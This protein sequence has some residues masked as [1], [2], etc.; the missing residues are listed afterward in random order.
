MDPKVTESLVIVIAVIL[1]LRLGWL[2]H[3]RSTAR[4]PIHG[5]ALSHACNFLSGLCFV[6]ILP[7]V[8]LSVLVL[9]PEALQLAGLSWHPL[10]L[11]V[12]TLGVGSLV[13]SLLHGLFERA[14]MQ[15]AQDQIAARD[16]RGWTEEDARTS[17]L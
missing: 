3:S 15:R 6:A 16:A 5:G 12:L 13:F 9:R 14:P 2:V 4:Q 8:C 17:G 7:T 10:L 1:V 11:V